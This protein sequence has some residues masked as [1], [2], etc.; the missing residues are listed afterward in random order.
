[1]AIQQTVNYS[2]KN[3]ISTLCQKCQGKCYVK[4]NNTQTQENAHNL[5]G[6][7][8]PAEC[9]DLQA[10]TPNCPAALGYF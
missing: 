5:L 6:E 7:T 4:H 2:R 8:I 3:D 1:M 9:V 10:G